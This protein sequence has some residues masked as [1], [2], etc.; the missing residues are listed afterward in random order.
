[1]AIK[2]LNVKNL[3]PFMVLSLILG[4][5]LSCTETPV[6]EN[7][8]FS[9]KNLSDSEYPDNPD[10]GFRSEQYQN[11]YFTNGT[12]IPLETN[13]RMEFYSN[14]QDTFRLENLDLLEY[15]PTIPDSVK[16]D[17]YL[18]YIACINQEWNRN[19]VRFNNNYFTST[20]DR[21]VRIDLARN[22]LNAYL[23]EIILY[24]EEDGKQLP[25]AHGWFDFPHTLY[26]EL[27]EVKNDISF[28]TYRAALEEWI[29]PENKRVNLS[30][31]RTLLAPMKISFQDKSDAMYPLEGARKKK[32]KEIIYPEQFETMRDLQTDSTLFATFTPPGFYNRKD[33]RTTQLGRFY[34]LEAINL[35]KM[36][37]RINS[38][39]L[40]ELSFSFSDSEHK[41]RTVLLIGGVDISEF[42]I[43]PEADANNGWKSSMG[44]GNHSFYED[45]ETHERI[46]ADSNPYYALLMD[47]EGK[48][49]DSH[50]VGIDGPIFHFSDDDKNELHLWLLSFERHALVGHYKINLK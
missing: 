32:F 12:L 34:H 44:I 41:R 8:T 50:T 2:S 49:L 47:D 30:R 24:V 4:T 43:L 21:I 38:D 17:Q 14:S 28:E 23:W 15:I 39:T 11:E 33:P 1:M 19:Q 25:Y 13:F 35:H 42:P 16:A 31:L 6:S 18:S 9:I 37:S 40:Y 45:Y 26:A 10:I 20:D 7:Y 27:F 22:C 46:H 3:L 5:H 36:Q 48:W 29:N